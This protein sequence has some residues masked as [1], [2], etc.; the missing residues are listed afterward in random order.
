MSRR[1]FNK[2][3]LNNT[4]SLYKKPR[5]AR[6]L[7]KAITHFSSPRIAPVTDEMMENLDFTLHYWS[8][9]DKFYKLAHKYYGDSKLW[10]VI[11]WFN[12]KPTDHHPSTGDEIYIPGPVSR[13]LA[14]LDI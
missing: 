7:E 4:L 12:Q 13:L 2:A 11:A 3:V 10:W 8:T 6:N 9:G 5:E 1:N 14:V